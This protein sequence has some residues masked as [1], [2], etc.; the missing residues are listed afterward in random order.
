MVPEKQGWNSMQTKELI[1]TG[2]AM[3]HPQAYG[4]IHYLDE[5][6]LDDYSFHVK[7]LHH[8]TISISFLE[9]MTLESTKIISVLLRKPQ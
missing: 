5:S 4:V 9:W 6:L 7:K 8:K 2:G 3:G 1:G